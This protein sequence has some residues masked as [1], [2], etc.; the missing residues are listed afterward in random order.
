MAEKNLIGKRAIK[1]SGVMSL[2][3]LK[4]V[5]NDWCKRND[6]KVYGAQS[7]E[8]VYAEAKE[9]LYKSDLKANITDWM[10][11]NIK[12]KVDL[13]NMQAVDVEIDEISR[14]MWKADVEIAIKGIVE[15]DTGDSWTKQPAQLF[16][17]EL[18]DRFFALSETKKAEKYCNKAMDSLI[19]ELRTYMNLEKMAIE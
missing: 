11:I 1:Y 17:R 15:S 6:Y 16:F 19:E 14:E 12:L 7:E 10:K 13:R 4:K 5:I 8:K 18:M 3:S 9:I 2:S